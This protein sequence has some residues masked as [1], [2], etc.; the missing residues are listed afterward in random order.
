MAGPISGAS[1]SGGDDFAIHHPTENMATKLLAKL[2]A[3]GVASSDNILTY[4]MPRS[5][6]LVAMQ[7]L[8]KGTVAAAVTEFAQFEISLASASQFTQAEAM[9]VIASVAVAAPSATATL[10]TF[11]QFNIGGLDLQID[12]GAKIYVHRLATVPLSACLASFNFYF[13]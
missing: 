12:A 1:L 8:L 4:T 11:A 9:G 2:Y 5:L 3:S 6:R 7:I 13:A 10:V